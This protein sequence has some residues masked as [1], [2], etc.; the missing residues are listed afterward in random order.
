M[1][2]E[3]I[4]ERL[5]AELASGRDADIVGELSALVAEN[6]LRE[7]P[8]GQLML[9]LYRA[10]RQAEA[11]ETMRTGR[12]LLVDQLG[13][14]PGPELRRLE[15]MILAHDPELSAERPAGLATPLPA[16]VNETI[17]RTGELAGI[18]PLL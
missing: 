10:G 9:A 5:A 16:P 3:A 2:M 17:G 15:R 4:E 14:E 6:P 13:I 12:R 1:R 7:R 18:V 11:L 8:R